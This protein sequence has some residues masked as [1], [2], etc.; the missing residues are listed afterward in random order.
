MVKLSY[1]GIWAALAIAGLAG[2][3][4][5]AADPPS[6]CPATCSPAACGSPDTCT[7]P[8]AGTRCV[9]EAR[10]EGEFRGYQGDVVLLAVSAPDNSCQQVQILSKLPYVSKLFESPNCQQRSDCQPR[11]VVIAIPKHQIQFLAATAPPC[12]FQNCPTELAACQVA[13]ATTKGPATCCESACCESECCE[14]VKRGP[15]CNECPV[16][17]KAF[18]V[19]GWMPGIATKA[20]EACNCGENC[21]CGPQQKCQPN[22]QCGPQANQIAACPVLSG[23]IA[24]CPG[25]ANQ[26]AACP[27]PHG[28]RTVKSMVVVTRAPRCPARDCPVF[29]EQIPAPVPHGMQVTHLPV[30]PMVLPPPPA[31]YSHH[32]GPPAG[33]HPLIDRLMKL[34]AEN[35][36][37][38]ARSEARDELMAE[39]EMFLESL[40]EAEVENAQ[41][42]ARLEMVDQRDQL[43]Q[44]LVDAAVE[45]A[46][47]EGHLHAAQ[48]RAAMAGEV[49]KARAHS[50]DAPQSALASQLVEAHRENQQLR[51]RLSEL[52]S[53]MKQI[54]A[55]MAD[56]SAAPSPSDVSTPR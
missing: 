1:V 12:G 27:V 2:S 56:S 52:E 26:I 6:S 16:F 48:E 25:L 14:T 38:K 54:I 9:V 33:D 49:A 11:E 24:A 3:R 43:V 8:A 7:P 15:A 18:A 34:T 17:E 55:R 29:A 30:P 41:L 13:C 4:L 42:Q 47:M 32:P 36:T 5:V 39:R 51:E 19:L 20:C 21:G 10:I 45:K 46:R 40:V 31:V 53:Q 23:Q 28:Q 22:C 37:L 35:A 44:H 50:H